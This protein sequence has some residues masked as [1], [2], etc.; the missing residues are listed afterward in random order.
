MATFA[1]KLDKELLHAPLP[2][3]WQEELCNGVIR[4]RDETTGAISTKR[5]PVGP[6]EGPMPMIELIMGNAARS[7][8]P[9][10]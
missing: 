5:N 4:Y 8:W 9:S 7:K 6:L 1:D 10:W 3:G 2:G